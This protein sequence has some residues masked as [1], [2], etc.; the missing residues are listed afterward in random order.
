MMERLVSLVHLDPPE[1]LVLLDHQEREGLLDLQD[2]REDK[3][4]RE[5]RESLG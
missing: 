2:L 4:R 1:N 5:A 3:E